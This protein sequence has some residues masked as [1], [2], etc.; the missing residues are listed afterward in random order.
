MEM[1]QAYLVRYKWGYK[2]CLHLKFEVQF[3]QGM[4]TGDYVCTTCGREF[5]K[6]EV[7]ALREARKTIKQAQ[8]THLKEGI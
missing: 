7:R 5:A 3:Y 2:P 4:P 8:D 1:R 6:Q